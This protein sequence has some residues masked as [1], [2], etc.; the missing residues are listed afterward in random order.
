[1]KTELPT[2]TKLSTKTL[3]TKIERAETGRRYK[4]V[5]S[6]ERIAQRHSRIFD[7]GVELFGTRGYHATTMAMLSVQSGVPHRYLISIFP[8]KES[9]LREIH[10]SI[11]D[12]I[13]RAVRDVPNAMPNDPISFVRQGVG[14]AC[15]VLLEDMR[16]L[17]IGCLEVGG[18][19]E[20]FE[21]F[22]RNMIRQYFPLILESIDKFVAKGMLPRRDEYYV[23]MAVGLVGAYNALMTEWALTAPE[24]R[25]APEVLIDQISEFFRGTLLAALYQVSV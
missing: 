12:D 19:S 23:A 5:D 21:Q 11:I 18:I 10:Q 8:D 7:A 3:P 16:K 25:P 9:L 20:D 17:R 22:R 14:A 6:S 1:M 15:R 24:Q 2:K 4:G 13:M